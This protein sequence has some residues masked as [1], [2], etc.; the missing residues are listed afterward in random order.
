MARPR[1]RS[2]R[3]TDYDWE[4]AL[5]AQTSLVAA[6]IVEFELF[7]SDT[8]E[9]L[10]RVRGEV[11]AHL[12]QG[13]STAGDACTVGFG[14]IRAPTGATVAVSPLSQPGAN[15][16]WHSFMNLAN[17]FV[18]ASGNNEELMQA[19]IQIDNKAMRK[20]REDESI[21]LVI[22]NVDNVGAPVV[23]VNGA[24]RVLTGR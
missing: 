1:A 7:Q 22:E 18:V 11:T 20:L 13:G 15:W 12:D 21:F 24:F 4:G 16:L 14:L 19:R 3:P 23:L 9:T 5:I 6:A 8:A 10:M 17:E 2:G